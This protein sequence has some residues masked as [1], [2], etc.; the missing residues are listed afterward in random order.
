MREGVVVMLPAAVLV[1]WLVNVGVG[2][3]VPGAVV[4]VGLTVEVAV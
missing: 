3:S 4:L 1:G 2:V